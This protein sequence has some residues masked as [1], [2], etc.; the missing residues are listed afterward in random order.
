MVC[1]WNDPGGDVRL[2]LGVAREDMKTALP[3]DELSDDLSETFLFFR[4]AVCFLPRAHKGC[5]LL[6]SV[7]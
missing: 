7:P 3:I 6:S 5:M 2:V 1:L 4:L